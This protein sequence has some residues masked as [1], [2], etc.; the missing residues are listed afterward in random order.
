V[1]DTSASRSLRRPAPVL[2][3]LKRSTNV[4]YFGCLSFEKYRHQIESPFLGAG[5]QELQN[6]MG[7][8]SRRWL[9]LS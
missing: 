5:E 4:P 6:S 8:F 3:Y 9:R 2:T 7:L 1:F